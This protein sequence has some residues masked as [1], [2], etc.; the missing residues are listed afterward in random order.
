[1]HVC[2]QVIQF[3]KIKHQIFNSKFV[4]MTAGELYR[5]YLKLLSPIYGEGESSTITAIVFETIANCSRI[6]IITNPSTILDAQI[7]NKLSVCLE[8]LLQHK[9]VQYVLGEALFCKLKFEV[10][11]SVLIPRPETEELVAEV[12]EF[13]K[14]KINH[15]F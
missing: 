4:I 3:R 14:T 10:D 9:P 5:N 6:D 2:V 15:P 8:E 11:E 13:A 12:I 7:E 1:M